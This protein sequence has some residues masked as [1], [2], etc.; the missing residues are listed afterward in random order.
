MQ[1]KV[2]TFLENPRV[3]NSLAAVLVFALF[4]YS[5]FA[6][7]RAGVAPILGYW[8]FFPACALVIVVALISDFWRA[9]RV[10][11]LPAGLRLV[12]QIYN[13]VARVLVAQVLLAVV[14]LVLVPV[15]ALLGVFRDPHG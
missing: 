8:C 5:G 9:D 2:R 7:I 11:E 3:Q 14:I 13:A 15:A 4:A 12:V 10:S 1:Q 6:V